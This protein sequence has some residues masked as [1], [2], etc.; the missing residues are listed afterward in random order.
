MSETVPISLRSETFRHIEDLAAIWLH[1]GLKHGVESVMALGSR[2]AAGRWLL[3]HYAGTPVDDSRLA[4]EVAGVSLGGPVGL[5]PGWDKPGKTVLAWQSLGAHHAT[6]GGVTFDSQHGNPMPRLHTFNERLG[7]FGTS[8][9]LNAYG[10]PSLGVKKFVPIIARQK[11]TG[12]LKIPVFVQV[13]VNKEFYEPSKLEHI[14][15]MLAATIREVLPVADGINVGLSSPNTLGMRD[16]QE[17]YEFLCRCMMAVRKATGDL[18]LGYKGDGDGGKRR[19]DTYARLALETGIDYFEL[20][21]TTTLP[22][23][24]GK[25]GLE[26]RPGGLAGADPDY[27]DLAE[28]A[29]RYFYEAVGDKVDII[30]MG[31][32]NTAVRAMRLIRAG[33]SAISINTA[34][35]EHGPR[36]MSA[37]ERDLSSMMDLY[38]GVTR[39]GQ[40]VGADTRRG[41]KLPLAA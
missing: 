32:V 2:N 34:V 4:T 25:Y 37:I 40:I 15:A 28:W 41:P 26:N 36:V 13:T 19:L 20:I 22:N 8:K 39:L 33:A 35:R 17:E 5:A 30:G 29:V 24:K 18:P 23:I 11:D 6:P 9:S 31:G 21:N 38:P 10:F 3:E 12:R 14:P 1:E 16:A 7:D 27:Q